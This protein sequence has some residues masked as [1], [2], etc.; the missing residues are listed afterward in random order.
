MVLAALHSSYD[1]VFLQMTDSGTRPRVPE[2]I[3]CRLCLEVCKRGVSLPCCSTIACRAC[4]TK[5]ITTTRTCWGCGQSTSTAA[6]VNNEQLR[7]NVEKFNKGDW[8]PCGEE[9]DNNSDKEDLQ[10]PA[11][12]LRAEGEEKRH[13]GGESGG[14]VE[15]EEAESGI[16]LQIMQ[17]RNIEFDKFLLPQERSCK[18][19]RVGAQLELVFQFTQA[20][21]LCLLC[22]LQLAEEVQIKEHLIDSHPKEFGNLKIVLRDD[23]ESAIEWIKKAIKSEFIYQRDKTFPVEVK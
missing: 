19:L 9:Q 4:A 22:S 2:S 18:Q 5:R 14:D 10:P 20:G 6:L 8:E 17:E 3:Q 21:A 15:G 23:H 13:E 16:T 11:K 7:Q 1:C 12:R